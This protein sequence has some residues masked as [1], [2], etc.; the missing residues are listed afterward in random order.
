[1]AEE[2]LILD[3]GKSSLRLCCELGDVQAVTYDS[4]KLSFSALAVTM[5]CRERSVSSRFFILT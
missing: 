4:M 1:M 3:L 5:L 2:K